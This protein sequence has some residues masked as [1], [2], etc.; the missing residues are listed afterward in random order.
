MT[1]PCTSYE[2]ATKK[3][4]FQT[5]MLHAWENKISLDGG[6]LTVFSFHRKHEQLMP[7]KTFHNPP[8]RVARASPFLQ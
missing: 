1:T 7:D 5:A 2:E 4:L 8:G 6:M 3:A